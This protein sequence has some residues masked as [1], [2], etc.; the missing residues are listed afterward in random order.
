MISDGVRARLAPVVTSVRPNVSNP[1]LRTTEARQESQRKQASEREG[2][3]AEAEEEKKKKSE[4][5]IWIAQGKIQYGRQYILPK[6][7][8]KDPDLKKSAEKIETHAQ[9][10]P[11]ESGIQRYDQSSSRLKRAVSVK[12][13]QPRH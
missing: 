9:K 13:Y 7:N 11:K 6:W 2:R 5:K 12:Q 4:E 3:R 8:P 10:S 1:S